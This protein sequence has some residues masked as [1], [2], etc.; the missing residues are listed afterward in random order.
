MTVYEVNYN[1]GI[2][3]LKNKDGTAGGGPTE[4]FGDKS[5]KHIFTDAIKSALENKTSIEEHLIDVEKKAKILSNAIETYKEA[6]KTVRENQSNQNQDNETLNN[7]LNKSL[8][9]IKESIINIE[10]GKRKTFRKKNKKNKKSKKNNSKN[11][12]NN[13]L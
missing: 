11:K 12:H 5:P 13:R 1:D 3:T 4:P 8:T 6:V 9:E 10:G 7:S 2:F